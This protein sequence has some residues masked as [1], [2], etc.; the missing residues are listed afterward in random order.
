MR[1]TLLRTAEKNL[2]IEVLID[3]LIDLCR[4][5]PGDIIAGVAREWM[6]TRRFFPI[7][8][9][10]IVACEEAVAFR[11]ALMRRFEEAR[12]PLLA[13]KAEARRISADSRLGMHYKELPRRD[14]LPCHYEWWIGDAEK[15]VALTKEHGRM[16]Q[17]DEWQIELDRR[18]AERE[19][20]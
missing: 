16:T 6:K 9:E 1:M 13:G 18:N 2:G 11:R 4:E 14:W 5:Y 15:M 19:A 17:A 12:N 7:P 10:C 3:T 8:R 20:A